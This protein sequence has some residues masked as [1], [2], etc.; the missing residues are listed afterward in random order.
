MNQGASRIMAFFGFWRSHGVTA[1]GSK[2]WANT[3]QIVRFQAANTNVALEQGCV[4][5]GRVQVGRVQVG[6]GVR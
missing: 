2:D 4:Q 3:K 5:G 1:A 6:R